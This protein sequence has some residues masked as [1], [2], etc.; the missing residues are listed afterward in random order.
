MEFN[1]AAGSSSLHSYNSDLVK[2]LQDLR[3]KREIVH[4]EI[5]S[6][7]REKARVQKQLADL[8]EQLQRLNDSIGRKTQSRNDYDKTIHETEA[9]YMK[10]PSFYSI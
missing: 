2:C 4:K 3:Q 6:E 9:A 7:E 8:T 5:V 10:V 1:P